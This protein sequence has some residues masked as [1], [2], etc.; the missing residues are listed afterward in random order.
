MFTERPL[1]ARTVLRLQG[2]R[3]ND[4]TQVVSRRDYKTQTRHEPLSPETQSHRRSPSVGQARVQW[5]KHGSPQ[6]L[7][8]GLNKSSCLGLLSSQDHRHPSPH[9]ANFLLLASRDLPALASQSAGIADVSHHT[10]PNS[11]FYVSQSEVE[12]CHLQLEEESKVNLLAGERRGFSMLP[13]LVLELLGSTDPPPWP[14]KVLGLQK[15]KKSQHPN[16]ISAASTEA[17]YLETKP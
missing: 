8:P 17:Q 11:L 9:P 14:L 5:C 3:V 7:P 10:W 16:A 4:T 2:T 6:P 13:M 15:S 1:L 12:F